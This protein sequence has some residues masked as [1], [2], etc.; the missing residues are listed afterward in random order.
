MEITSSAERLVFIWQ[1]IR[2]ICVN[3]GSLSYFC[4][5]KLLVLITYLLTYLLT[6]LLTYSEEQSFERPIIFQQVK[7][8]LAFYGSRRFITTFTSARNL[9]LSWA[10]SMQSMPSHLT[11]W[12]SILILY[13]YLLMGLPSGLFPSGFHTKP[14]IH[15]H[16]PNTCY[17]PRSLHSSRFG[18][19]NNVGWGVQ[20]LRVL[21]FVITGLTPA[22][23]C[24]S[25]LHEYM[26]MFLAG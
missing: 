15:L 21:T 3:F 11:S 22:S 5:L 2:D 17:M 10:R 4:L 24:N 1:S 26:C 20:M 6:F 7:I 25:N 18:H 9:S 14:C 19:P 23:T 13:S 12:R 16:F 8:F